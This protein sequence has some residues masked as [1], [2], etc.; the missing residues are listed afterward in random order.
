MPYYSKHLQSRKGSWNNGD[1]ALRTIGIIILWLV[2]IIVL[3]LVIVSLMSW[4]Y[5]I[6]MGSRSDALREIQILNSE[7][8]RPSEFISAANLIPGKS[9]LPSTLKVAKY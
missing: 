7:L 2:V 1:S 8:S 9:L 3:L 5:G 4:I 6:K